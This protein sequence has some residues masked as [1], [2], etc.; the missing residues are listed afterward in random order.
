MTQ[1]LDGLLDFFRGP[2]SPLNP[3]PLTGPNAPA[4]PPTVTSPPPSGPGTPANPPTVT[5]PPPSVP[6]GTKPPSTPP[7]PPPV[8]SAPGPRSGPA[9]P[10]PR[11]RDPQVYDPNV[12]VLVN[13]DGGQALTPALTA[14]QINAARAALNRNMVAGGVHTLAKGPKADGDPHADAPGAK[15]DDKKPHPL[16]GS[17]QMT[18][19]G[20]NL[21]AGYTAD[22][23]IT[24][25]GGAIHIASTYFVPGSGNYSSTSDGTITGPEHGPYALSATTNGI[26]ST[27]TLTLSA[28]SS[29][30]SITVRGLTST[31]RRTSPAPQPAKPGTG[32]Q[33]Y[34]APAAV[35]SSSSGAAQHTPPPATSPLD[36][37]GPLLSQ[38]QLDAA[39]N[40]LGR[41]VGGAAHSPPGSL[42][43]SPR[44]PLAAPAQAAL[45]GPM[46]QPTKPSVIRVPNVIGLTADEASSR[47]QA[48]GLNARSERGELASRPDES[49]T[50]YG[51]EPKGGQDVQPSSVV[52]ISIYQPYQQPTRVVGG[53]PA[54]YTSLTGDWKCS[55]GETWSL[56]Q[57]G[58]N[59][60]GQESMDGRVRRLQGT[61]TGGQFRFAF[62]TTDG[63]RGQ[64]VMVPD[65]ELKR[66]NWRM[67]LS[68]GETWDGSVQRQ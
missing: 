45:N 4:N 59:I 26:A 53:K 54:R 35:P 14:A 33:P 13:E 15:P 48:A 30:M 27:A 17:W 29:T 36:A 21:P 31:L 12:T 56:Q 62:Q 9:L 51:Q 67:T 32:D 5:N 25:N 3:P 34:K 8:A 23:V 61:F 60:V 50:V 52:F 16:A 11:S 65:P 28:D 39:R 19:P 1:A 44:A 49:E 18:A 7:P 40:A 37:G 55:C 47:I 46:P 2:N 22:I 20:A 64:G 24:V 66:M 38:A 41:A 42:N 10:T 57:Q 58:Q 68:T 6:G 43:N 63:E